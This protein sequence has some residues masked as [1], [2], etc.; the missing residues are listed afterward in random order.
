MPHA[1]SLMRTLSLI[2]PNLGKQRD[3]L[4]LLAPFHPV[5]PLPP[6]D[7]FPLYSGVSIS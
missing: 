6:S 2:K 3:E 5:I 7:P 4:Q 1:L